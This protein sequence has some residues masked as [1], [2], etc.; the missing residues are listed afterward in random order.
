MTPG[1]AFLSEFVATV[2]GSGGTAPAG[3]VV[4]SR[5]PDAPEVVPPFFVAPATAPP[6]PPPLQYVISPTTRTLHKYMVKSGGVKEVWDPKE[7]NDGTTKVTGVAAG[8]GGACVALYL[9]FYFLHH[10][11]PAACRCKLKHLHE[12]PTRL[13]EA[14]VRMQSVV[15]LDLLLTRDSLLYSFPLLLSLLTSHF[16]TYL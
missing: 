1:A 9:L 3:L 10:Y 13:K 8:A 7:V 6:T 4:A 12:D 5:N 16:S 14:K 15:F 11:G 2:A